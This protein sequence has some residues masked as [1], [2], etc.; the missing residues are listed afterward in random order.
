[1]S[2][3]IWRSIAAAPAQADRAL[4]P[5]RDYRNPIGSAAM[6]AFA[7]QTKNLWMTSARNPRHR[8]SRRWCLR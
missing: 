4:N 6:N 2:R 8:H 5:A 7:A 3:H 1:M